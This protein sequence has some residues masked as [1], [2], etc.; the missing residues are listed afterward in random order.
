[1]SSTVIATPVIELQPLAILSLGKDATILGRHLT[2][3][4]LHLKAHR[5]TADSSSGPSVP[6]H[7]LY[8][9]G[10]RQLNGINLLRL[11]L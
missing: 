2:T 3:H 8:L 4:A 7:A 6:L 11:S 5:L 9:L 1:M 10:A